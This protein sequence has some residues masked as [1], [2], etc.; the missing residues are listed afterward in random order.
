[1]EQLSFDAN[2][3]ERFEVEKWIAEHHWLTKQSQGPK[4]QSAQE[5]Q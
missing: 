3:V 5:P 4:E 1:M 2:T